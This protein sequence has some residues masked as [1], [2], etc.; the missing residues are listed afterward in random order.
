MEAIWKQE[1]SDVDTLAF[2]TLNNYGLENMTV[3]YHSADRLIA[4]I[5]ITSG[6]IFFRMLNYD[7]EVNIDDTMC[8]KISYKQ[9]VYKTDIKIVSVIKTKAANVLV[10]QFADGDAELKEILHE[11]S[12]NLAVIQR[13]VQQY[14][15]HG[16]SKK[17]DTEKP[18]YED[19][20]LVNRELTQKVLYY[21][22]IGNETVTFNNKDYLVTIVKIK[23][24]FFELMA[25]EKLPITDGYTEAVLGI[26][27]N[28][29]KYTAAIKMALSQVEDDS[30]CIYSTQLTGRLDNV[31]AE[32]IQKITKYLS[33]MD[34]R[35]DKRIPCDE[36]T[37]Q[38]FSIEPRVFINSAGKDYLGFIKNIS[39]RGMNVV[40][41]HEL[42]QEKDKRLVINVGFKNP[43]ESMHLMGEIVRHKEAL[44]MGNV[45]FDVGIKV[46]ENLFLEKRI[47][48]Y[49]MNVKKPHIAAD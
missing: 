24:G 10:A 9:E 19:K 18:A 31:L 39:M 3:V 22:N 42:L 11:M 49:M 28:D 32:M 37:L 4:L 40:T 43:A 41:D 29:I 14:M 38:Y 21:F 47:I 20:K 6:Q 2:R 46:D 8:L 1:E 13:E 44:V 23:N 25:D 34:E 36:E 7:N 16:T 30:S 17:Q 33:Y 26:T 5:N 48:D 45:L 12:M 27:I 15:Y 35:G